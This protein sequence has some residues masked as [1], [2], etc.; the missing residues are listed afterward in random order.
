MC[1]TEESHIYLKQHEDYFHF[2]VN[3]RR[4]KKVFCRFNTLCF[5]NT[6]AMQI[7][8]VT[9]AC[10]VIIM[11]LFVICHF[12]YCSGTSGEFKGAHQ[13]G[14]HLLEHQ[15]WFKERQTPMQLKNLSIDCH[16]DSHVLLRPAM[17]ADCL[18]ICH[19]QRQLAFSIRIFFFFFCKATENESGFR[20]SYSVLY[21]QRAKKLILFY[22]NINK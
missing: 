15:W 10:D 9:R 13:R 20:F 21:M 22:L 12:S 1:F 6:N 11:G 5:Q 19:S 16:S 14:L 3:S 17:C 18:E 4:K 7:L 2:L 8:Y